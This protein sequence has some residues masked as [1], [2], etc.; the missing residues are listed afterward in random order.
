MH[1]MTEEDMRH[2]HRRGLISVAELAI[3]TNLSIEAVN[4]ILREAV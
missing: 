2:M 1:N 4:R 3:M